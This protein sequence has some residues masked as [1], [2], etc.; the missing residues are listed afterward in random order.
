MEDDP[1]SPAATEP[2]AKSVRGPWI[3]RRLVGAKPLLRPRD[4]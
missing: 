1:M 3:K 4:V 2:A